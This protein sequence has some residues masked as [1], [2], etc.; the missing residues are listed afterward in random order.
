MRE[1][2]PSELIARRARTFSQPEPQ[3]RSLTEVG[4]RRRRSS[5]PPKRQRLTSPVYYQELPARASNGAPSTGL[6][7]AGKP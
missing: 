1:P 5:L 4:A 7:F 6:P 3:A 2:P